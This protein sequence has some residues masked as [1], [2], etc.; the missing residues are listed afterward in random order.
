MINFKD[1]FKIRKVNNEIHIGKWYTGWKSK[2]FSLTYDECGYEEPN[3]QLNISMFGWHNHIT[4]PFKSKRFPYGDCDSPC[5]GIRIHDDRIW[6]CY[7]GNG[8][9]SG[10]SKSISFGIPFFEKNCISRCIECYKRNP[11]GTLSNKI[12]MVE[13][14]VLE[15][16]LKDIDG[17]WH[18]IEEN[19]RIVKRHKKFIDTYDK[20]EI[21]ALY[22]IEYMKY[23]RK[24]FK[25]TSLGEKIYKRID[26]I[27]DK[28][29]GP[30]K[31]EWKGGTTE[32]SA[33]IM[34][35]E[36]EEQ[37]FKRIVEYECEYK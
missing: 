15:K 19:E 2:T 11:D 36:T 13:R 4:L 23:R 16:E 5:W 25:W 9:F 21:N 24:Y 30:E 29:I 7:G 35:G 26:I 27:F 10:G 33:C 37:A 14:D 17:K 18:P 1:F 34:D 20:E 31:D 32:V 6:L 3:G 28:G 8:N 12:E 22:Y